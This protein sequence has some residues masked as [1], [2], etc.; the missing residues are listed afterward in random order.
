MNNLI[1]FCFFSR[2]PCG[3]Q[4]SQETFT[5]DSGIH[6]FVEETIANDDDKGE[7][8]ETTFTK[9]N[10]RN[11]HE[12]TI[13]PTVQIPSTTTENTITINNENDEETNI[14]VN[15]RVD[16]GSPWVVHAGSDLA[17][18]FSNKDAMTPSPKKK[19]KYDLK[20]VAKPSPKKPLKCKKISF[21]PILELRRQERREERLLTVNSEVSIETVN[22]GILEFQHWDH[23]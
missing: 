11:I 6:T 1:E 20:K 5:Q 15:V 9:L 16:V 10:D 13:Y 12:K 14:T 7:P 18:S 2:L 4:L 8:E 21:D 19:R 3:V 17:R 22:Q 23:Q